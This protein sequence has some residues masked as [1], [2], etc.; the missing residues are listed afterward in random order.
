M[1]LPRFVSNEDRNKDAGRDLDAIWTQVNIR[2]SVSGGSESDD[3]DDASSL[4]VISRSGSPV[5]EFND[6]LTA[7]TQQIVWPPTLPWFQLTGLLEDIVYA[8]LARSPSSQGADAPMHLALTIGSTSVSLMEGVDTAAK[9]I[10]KTMPEL[11]PGEHRTRLQVVASGG[12]FEA[13]LEAFQLLCYQ[14]SNK[15]IE[16][17]EFYAKDYDESFDK[18]EQAIRMFRNLDLAPELWV[19]IFVKQET[20]TGSAFAEALFEAAINQKDLEI[21]TSLLKSGVIDPDQPVWTWQVE[22]MQCPVQWAASTIESPGHFDLLKLLVQLGADVN[23]WT[24]DA[25]ASALYDAARSGSLEIVRFLVEAGADIRDII[26]EK[27][28]C[29]GMTTPLTEAVSNRQGLE[30]DS[31]RPP[32]PLGDTGRQE[33]ESV[34]VFRYILLLHDRDE[35]HAVIQEALIAA[36]EAGR[37]DLISLLLDSGADLQEPG[38]KGFTALQVAVSISHRN[39]SSMVRQLL[40]L[41]AETRTNTL[42]VLHIAALRSDADTLSALI[43]HGEDV[44]SRTP[45]LTEREIN[46]LGPNYPTEAKDR[47]RKIARLLHTP[48]DLALEVE[49]YSW[50]KGRELNALTLL[51]AGARL[52]G[53][54]LVRAIRLKSDELTHC[55]LNQGADINERWDGHTALQVCFDVDALQMAENL[56]RAGARLQG[57]EVCTAFESGTPEFIET[58]LAHGGTIDDEQDH[59]APSPLERACS[60]QNWRVVDW[61]LERG[62]DY[63]PGALCAAVCSTRTEIPEVLGHI[64]KLLE[65]RKRVV[66]QYSPR[67]SLLEGTAAGY[68]ALCEHDDILKQLLTLGNLDKCVLP[69]AASKGLIL[70]LE[71]ELHWVKER[72]AKLGWTKPGQN[73]VSILVP[74]ILSR[75]WDIVQLLLDK[76]YRPD[77][78]ALLAAIRFFQDDHVIQLLSAGARANKRMLKDFDTPLQYAAR[79]GRLDVVRTLLRHGA[80]VNA[81]APKAKLYFGYPPV[82]ALQ[83]A[84]VT[85]DQELIDLLLAAGADVNAAPSPDGGATALQL[86]AIKGYLPIAQRLLEAG[87][88]VDAWRAR[89]AGRTALEGAAEHGRLDMVQFLLE[90]GARTFD[91]GA[92]QYHRAMGFA[93]KNGHRTVLRLLEDWEEG[94]MDSFWG[95]WEWDV[96]LDDDFRESDAEASSR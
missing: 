47:F 6:V 4:V 23:K 8:R 5:I 24:E 54:E 56:V 59:S 40:E 13:K 77:S 69:L 84:T 20:H 57:G 32:K 44:N 92:C 87:A 37:T 62:L 28:G 33:T 70:V 61:A 36:A 65:H 81:A 66:S 35:D 73:T 71:W 3:D 19:E 91:D 52:T 30:E 7:A 63:S 76:G 1:S 60:K 12:E 34:K 14:L 89:V 31:Q 11:F 38:R 78:L 55:I 39:N 21:I 58:L 46:F 85:G 86:A 29:L 17:P 49:V 75:N 83:A 50:D 10:S 96:L 64:E 26:P 90:N 53:G 48:L 2:S 27:R 72:Y 18:Y 74:A 9:A 45:G 41:G 16:D 67:W 93:R 68:A 80:N 94:H 88:Q 25:P 15:L 42:S 22:G 82:T 51:R 95:D 79:L 43:E